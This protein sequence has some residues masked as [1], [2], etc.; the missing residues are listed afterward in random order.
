MKNIADSSNTYISIDIAIL[1]YLKRLE[2]DGENMQNYN[3]IGIVFE[4]RSPK[5][6]AS[7]ADGRDEER[8]FWRGTEIDQKTDGEQGRGQAGEKYPTVTAD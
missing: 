8:R 4:C 5:R 6:H 2:K 1:V 3:T 7:A